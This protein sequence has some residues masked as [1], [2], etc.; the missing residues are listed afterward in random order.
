MFPSITDA[1][2]TQFARGGLEVL[3]FRRLLG[4]R[5]AA[6]KAKYCIVLAF[7]KHLRNWILLSMGYEVRPEVHSH[8]KESAI[9]GAR[10]AE[11]VR[12]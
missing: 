1:P 9:G 6:S 2:A 3:R 8:S 11:I 7:K 4:I 10:S 12:S 5:I